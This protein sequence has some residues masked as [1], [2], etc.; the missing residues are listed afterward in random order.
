MIIP[1]HT[2]GLGGRVS[3]LSAS[4]SGSSASA[5]GTGGGPFTTNSI[6]VTAS[7]GTAPYTYS[8]SKVSGDTM[9]ISSST[10]AT[11]SWTDSG[12]APSSLNSVW[13][14]TVTDSASRTV[15]SA[16]VSVSISFNLSALTAGLSTSSLS[17]SQTGDGSLTTG[18]VTANPS[19]GL[20]PYT[21][22][23]TYVSGDGTIAV[24]SATAQ[25]VTFSRT[26]TAGNTYSAVWQ[27]V[28]SDSNSS[29]VNA[30]TV[31]I[32]FTFSVPALS[33][34]LSNSSASATQVGTGTATTTPTITATPS[35]GTA[36]YTYNWQYISGDSSVYPTN[37]T[38]AATDFARFGSPEFTYVSNYRC[39][40]TDSASNTVNSATVGITIDFVY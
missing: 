28:V 30:G 27:C 25:T 8:W 29:S 5:S 37:P 34:S 21:Y 3:T 7:G 40:V 16:N 2:F 39:V 14:C 1:L 6:T 13:K 4:L 22:S 19:G 23:W 9:T 20:A 32:S 31:S 26:G 11:V 17:A 24:S 38:S 33:V 18:S 36:P 12:T 15:D 35:G 10:A